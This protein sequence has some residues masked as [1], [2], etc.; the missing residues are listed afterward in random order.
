MRSLPVLI[1]LVCLGPA[2]A[3][4]TSEPGHWEY[5]GEDGAIWVPERPGAAALPPPGLGDFHDYD[6]MT[7]ALQQLAAAHPSLATLQSLGMSVQGRHVWALTMR[8]GPDDGRPAVLYDGA[9]HGDEVIASEILVRYA[10]GL[11]AGYPSSERARTILEGTTVVLVPMVNPDG[12]GVA[13]TAS[14]YAIARKNA[15]GVDLNRNYASTWGGPGSSGNPGDATYRGPT[16]ASEPETR[17]MQT[18]LA[19]RNWTFYSSLHSGAEMILW[20]YGHVT[21]SP[22]EVGVYTRLGNEL[23]AITSAP[24][25]QVSKILYSVSGDSMD[26]AYISAGP[27]WKPISMSPETFEGSGDAFNWWPLFNPP[28]A[29]IPT[30]VA[31]WTAFLDHLAREAQH[32]APAGFALPPPHVGGGDAFTLG[33]QVAT[34]FKRPFL[35]ANASVA[36]PGFIDV[37]SPNP[38]ALGALNG[39]ASPMW[40]LAPRSGGEGALAFRVNAGPAGNVTGIT[41][42]RITAPGVSLALSKSVAGSGEVVTATARASSDVALTGTATITYEGNV[43]AVRNVTLDGLSDVT[44]SVP[45]DTGSAPGGVR[46][47]RVQMSYT[48]IDSVTGTVQSSAT[49]TIERPEIVVTRT[50]LSSARVGE[51]FTMIVT[52]RNVGAMMAR[53]VRITEVVPDGYV[54]AP[55]DAGIPVPPD[56][57]ARPAPKRVNVTADGSVALEWEMLG[58]APGSA[59]SYQLRLLPVLP[60]EHALEARTDYRAQY[61]GRSY[62]YS[63]AHLKPQT[64]TLG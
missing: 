11:A 18:L 61:T 46:T 42:V 44:W 12:I 47:V 29:Q 57:I 64:A 27:Y 34:P 8:A 30:V 48:T 62:A 26:H 21:S 58:L 43:V 36:A 39:T 63:E 53:D 17:A 54:L 19:S 38:V 25:G 14:H 20:P 10:Q 15:N 23:T 35:Y 40:T 50:S 24:N 56:P 3:A 4:E 37:V 1:A 32:Y 55:R 13:H 51:P 60:G 22:P 5:L 2:L 49:L 45:L 31:R 28:D 59:F 9:H 7:A 33:A 6:E 16:P 52:A 41:P